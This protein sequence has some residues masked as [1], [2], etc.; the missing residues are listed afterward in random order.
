M[1]YFG[2]LICPFSTKSLLRLHGFLLTRLFFQSLKKQR[3][4]KTP[5]YM[6]CH[7]SDTFVGQNHNVRLISVRW[8][9]ERHNTI[10]FVVLELAKKSYFFHHKVGSI[11]S[12]TRVDGIF[13]KISFHH[14]DSEKRIQVIITLRERFSSQLLT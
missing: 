7:F 9:A 13:S 1:V 5:L 2:T 8:Y 6:Y 3:K 14:V 11:N 4:Q 10:F 12:E